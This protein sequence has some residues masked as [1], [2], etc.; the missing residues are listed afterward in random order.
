MYS[1]VNA[2]RCAAGI[3]HCP[4]VIL[5]GIELMHMIKK[6]QMKCRGETPLSPPEQF[7]SLN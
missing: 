6:A 1:R 5:C 7:Y 3:F 4:S 2:V